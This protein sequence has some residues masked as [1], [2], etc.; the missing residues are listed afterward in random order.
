MYDKELLEEF[1][2]KEKEYQQTLDE[3]KQKV[4]DKKKE[5]KNLQF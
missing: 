4:H 2:K 1:E 3:M 5:V